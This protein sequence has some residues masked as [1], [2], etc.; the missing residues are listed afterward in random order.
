MI[1][2]LLQILPAELGQI[3]EY[4]AI[5]MSTYSYLAIE[6]L[7]VRAAAFER[8]VAAAA[9]EIVVALHYRLLLG[10]SPLRLLNAAAPDGVKP[11]SAS[12]LQEACSHL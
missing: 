2:G 1:G 12:R 5:V 11:A 6:Q 9:V 4:S 7:I 10:R 3:I 8:V